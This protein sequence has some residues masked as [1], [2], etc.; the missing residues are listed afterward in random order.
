MGCIRVPRTDP[1]VSLGKYPKRGLHMTHMTHNAAQGL[2]SERWLPLPATPHPVAKT[3]A[4]RVWDTTTNILQCVGRPE[5]TCL[6][7]ASSLKAK[8]CLSDLLD[9]SPLFSFFL[10][11]AISPF[12]VAFRV[13]GS[14]REWVL[15]PMVSASLTAVGPASHSYLRVGVSTET[16]PRTQMRRTYTVSPR[17]EAEWGRQKLET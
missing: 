1:E 16:W 4:S 10:G 14:K 8:S 9:I 2:G 17:W 11:P 5:T 12:H 6:C 3:T 15:G 13:P 7:M